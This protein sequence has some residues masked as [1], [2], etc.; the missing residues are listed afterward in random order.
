MVQTILKHVKENIDNIVRYWVATYYTKTDE[1]EQRKEY[2]GFLSARTQEVTQ[3]FR[4]TY[5]QLKHNYLNTSLFQNVGED[6]KDIGT[7]LVETVGNL[8]LVF[9][10]TLEYLSQ[11][12][13]Q[14]TFTCSN[15]ALCQY[16][17]LLRKV[18]IQVEQDLIL[19][20]MK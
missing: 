7:P 8:H 1:Y 19:G 16:T 14:N 10:S 11:Q 15:I 12:L 20:Y 17:L 5:Q 9:T 2:D 6:C 18:E 13:Q 3:L 4:T